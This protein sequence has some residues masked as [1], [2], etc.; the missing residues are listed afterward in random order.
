MMRYGIG[1]VVSLLV[2]AAGL[3][4]AFLGLNARSYGAP[5]TAEPC[6]HPTAD[7]ITDVGIA[8][9]GG[10]LIAIVVVARRA[11]AMRSRNARKR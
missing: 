5:C 1:L 3:G 10:G 7:L 4:T 11:V 2:L 8:L 6:T 9:V